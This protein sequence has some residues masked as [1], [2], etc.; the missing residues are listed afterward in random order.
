LR[1]K[2]RKGFVQP[3]VAELTVTYANKNSYRCIQRF[4][5][6]C[7]SARTISET[8]ETK[9]KNS[10]LRFKARKGF[11]QPEVAARIVTYANKNTNDTSTVILLQYFI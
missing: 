5:P 1:F 6:K 7:T 3:E 10:S 9:K 11:A 8:P 4:V 2:A